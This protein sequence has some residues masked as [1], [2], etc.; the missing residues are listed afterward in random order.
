MTQRLD[1]VI[2]VRGPRSQPDLKGSIAMHH[3]LRRHP[4]R[5]RIIAAEV[6]KLELRLEERRAASARRARSVPFPRASDS[7]QRRAA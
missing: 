4:T 3:P 1:G 2:F 5:D 6:M 7:Q